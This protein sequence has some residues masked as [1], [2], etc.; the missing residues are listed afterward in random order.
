MPK[1][2][3]LPTYISFWL[4]MYNVYVLYTN[5]IRLKKKAITPSTIILY[6]KNRK[7]YLV[8][9]PTMLFLFSRYSAHRAH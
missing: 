1:H 3:K 6:E 4:Y 7:Y 9:M 8:Y 2:N 5:R